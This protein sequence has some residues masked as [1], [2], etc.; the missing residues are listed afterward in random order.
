MKTII[1]LIDDNRPGGIRSLL[2]DMSNAGVWGTEEWQV[3]SV[4]STKPI[5]LRRKF[6]VIVVHYSMAWRKLPA[7]TLLRA[8]NPNAKLIIVEHHYTSS[9]E[10]QSIP[11]TK[12]FRALLRTCY[13]MADEVV[14]VSEAQARW[15]R[16]CEVLQTGKLRTIPSCRNYAKFLQIPRMNKSTGPIVVGALGRVEHAKG[17]D[18]LVKAIAGLSDEKYTLRIAGEGSALPAL[19]EQAKHLQN[20]EFIGHLDDPTKFLANCD[21]LVMPSRTEAFGLVCAEAKASGLP[22]I[23]SDVDGLPEQVSDCGVVIEPESARSIREA[24]RFIAR[25][26]RLYA[27]GRRARKSVVNDWSDYLSAWSRTLAH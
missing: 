3:Q 23:V 27:F 20:V 21:V 16:S 24:L 18:L 10:Q 15:L 6:D 8:A 13:G 11:S 26:S 14:A 19:K 9:F 17:F 25:P 1:N 7:L 4:D 5:T 12:R 2:E 22:V